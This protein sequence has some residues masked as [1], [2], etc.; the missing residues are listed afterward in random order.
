MR[1]KAVRL[2]E[3]VALRAATA[4]GAIAALTPPESATAAAP[5]PARFKNSRLL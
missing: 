1:P 4:R 2:V 3:T 5:P